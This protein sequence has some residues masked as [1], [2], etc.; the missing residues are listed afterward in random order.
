MD[1]LNKTGNFLCACHHGF[2][3]CLADMIKSGK[4]AKYSLACLNRLLNVY[5]QG[6]ALGYDIGC[7]H[8]I[9]VSRSSLRHQAKALG[10][11]LYVSAFHSYVHNQK[12]QLS[13][14]PRFL[15]TARL[16]DF[17]MNERL[18]SKQNLTTHLYHH[19]S[20]YHW[21][22]TLNAFWSRWNDDC[23]AGIGEC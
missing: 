1:G 14:H 4:L 9:T 7:K 20:T 10:L 13:F 15:T 6:L 3:L 18:F 21:H 23:R 19:D 17:K 8:S 5:G 22:M 16:E 12:C 11:Q 2:V